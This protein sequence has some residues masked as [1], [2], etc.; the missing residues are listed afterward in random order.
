MLQV[1]LESTAYSDAKRSTPRPDVFVIGPCQ[2]STKSD[3]TYQGDHAWAAKQPI[4]CAQRHGIIYQVSKCN[5]TCC[6]AAWC[7][8]R[9]IDV[10][11]LLFIQ[12]IQAVTYVLHT[13]TR[14]H[15]PQTVEFASPATSMPQTQHKAHQ[16]EL[17]MCEP[18][19][20]LGAAACKSLDSN[21]TTD[22]TVSQ[23]PYYPTQPYPT[24]LTHV[25]RPSEQH[26][27]CWT[28]SLNQRW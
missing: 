25:C 4:H 1:S 23:T 28:R 19:W 16:C 20:T 27:D 9:P 24:W 26:A 14:C 12:I 18:I 15:S 2:P 21:E 3:L 13:V 8:I 7:S 17:R 11:L 5:S 10:Y 6:G 22:V